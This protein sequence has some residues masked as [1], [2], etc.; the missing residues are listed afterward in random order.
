MFRECCGVCGEW[1]RAPR[2]QVPPT[3]QPALA[4]MMLIPLLQLVAAAAPAEASAPPPPSWKHQNCSSC[5]GAGLLWCYYDDRCWTHTDPGDRHPQTCALNLDWCASSSQCKC[6]TCG[7]TRCQ[8]PAPAPNPPPAPQRPIQQIH[9]ALGKVAG[10]M[11]V[12]WTTIA[13][14]PEA[15]VKYGV[16]GAFALA[17]PGARCRFRSLPDQMHDTQVG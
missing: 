8:P 1:T 13:N 3:G 9:L 7:D 6:K 10:T 17:L 5:V 4:N 16:T 11:T 12:A 2:R 15:S 14:S